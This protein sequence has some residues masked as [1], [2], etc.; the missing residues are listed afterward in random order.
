[1]ADAN[2]ISPAVIQ[3]LLK[4]AA[5]KAAYGMQAY[6]GAE[7]GVAQVSDAWRQGK[8]GATAFP[9]QATT[10]SSS[11]KLQIRGGRL[12][13]SFQPNGEGN[14]FEMSVSDGKVALL[15]G[16]RII[17]APVHERGM[18]IASKGRMHK[19]F[20]A[21][22]AQ[23]K[24]NFYK[25]MA[26]SVQ[27][28]GGVKIPPRPFFEKGIANFEREGLPLVLQDFAESVAAYMTGEQKV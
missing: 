21:M 6:I 11:P 24:N 19:Y 22:Y 4:E 2:L 12:Y 16:T 3:G 17:Y 26:L 7:M 27:K 28:R 18:F 14:V 5:R 20:W 13:K 9:A 15:Y 23:T 1:M 25:V 8:P 10:W